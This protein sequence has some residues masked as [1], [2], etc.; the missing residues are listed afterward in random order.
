MK[1]G[2]SEGNRGLLGRTLANNEEK[3]KEETKNR[4]G[5]ALT[6]LNQKALFLWKKFSK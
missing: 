4:K 1:T 6:V 5:E 3:E 2:F